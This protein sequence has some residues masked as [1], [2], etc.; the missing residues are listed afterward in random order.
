LLSS[1]APQRL[2]ELLGEVG[3][4]AA[5]LGGQGDGEVRLRRFAAGSPLRALLALFH[6][7]HEIPITEASGFFDSTLLDEL[8]DAEIVRR[9]ADSLVSAYRI[10]PADGLLIMHDPSHPLRREFIGGVGPAARTLASLTLRHSV[11]SA[12]DLCAGCGYQALLLARHARTVIATDILPR[13]LWLTNFNSQLNGVSNVECRQGNFFE[14]VA[15]ERFD[16]IACNPPFIVSPDTEYAF[17]DSGLG[18]DSVSEMVLT[19]LTEHLND[20]GF[21][22]AI[23]N[24]GLQDGEQWEEPGTRWLTGRGCDAIFIRWDASEP[25]SYTAMWNAD[26][27]EPS[28]AE[29]AA[30]LDRWSAYLS[31][32]GFERIAQ[33]GVVLRR[34]A[35]TNWNLGFETS[36]APSGNA[37][38][39]IARMFAARDFLAEHHG[40]LLDHRFALVE[41]HR[42]DQ[43]MNF[44]NGSY[45]IFSA[46]MSL[47]DAGV[48]LQGEV[49]ANLIPLLF[50]LSSGTLREVTTTLAKEMDADLDELQKQTLTMVR[51]LFER[52][53]LK[54]LGP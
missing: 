3:Y 2:A 11:D 24:W 18:G 44:K 40:D 42:L 53:L 16:L 14:P 6:A 36:N 23:V 13:A 41:G 54:R 15:E 25:L 51:R 31:G 50:S 1:R 45:D 47:P 46:A 12:L 52:G 49:P 29:Y 10:S 5:L 35:G 37:A 17:R 8:A 4:A 38:H 48:G 20:G 39:Q 33:L 21:A 9:Q 43:G 30:A 27:R 7:G 26:L 32:L 22:T 19:S 34:R 28:P